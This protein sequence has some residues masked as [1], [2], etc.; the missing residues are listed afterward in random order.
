MLQSQK[1]FYLKVDQ[2]GAEGNLEKAYKTF[3]QQLNNPNLRYEAFDFHK[4][5]KKMRWDRLN[6]LIDRL[7]HEQ[8]EFSVFHLRDDGSLISIQDGVFRVNCIDNLDRTNVVQSMLAKRSLTHTLQKL[9]ILQIG[10]R[11]ETASQKFEMVFK[12][13]CGGDEDF[14][15]FNCEERV[16]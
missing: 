1:H 13:V 7:A 2:K 15:N 10:Q 11:V 3:I 14:R 5:C 8:D 12:G 4:E 6:I 16:Y 9:G